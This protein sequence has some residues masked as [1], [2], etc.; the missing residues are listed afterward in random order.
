MKLYAKSE[1]TQYYQE[2]VEGHIP[3]DHVFVLTG[4]GW[5]LD[6]AVVREITPESEQEREYIFECDK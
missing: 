6:K 4:S 5:Y 2:Y 3:L 1:F